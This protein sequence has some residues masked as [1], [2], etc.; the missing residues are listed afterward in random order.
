MA[1]ILAPSDVHGQYSQAD[2]HLEASVGPRER[3]TG[4]GFNEEK[5]LRIFAQVA[6]C[7]RDRHSDEEFWIQL[8][9]EDMGSGRESEVYP[10][11]RMDRVGEE[12]VQLSGGL[13]TLMYNKPR[14]SREERKEHLE[15]ERKLEME[16]GTH[17]T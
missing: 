13:V 7:Q 1:C 14:Y 3:R 10:W 11:E 2:R 17:D 16:R 5:W 9:P 12:V 15:R 4:F 6:I 8:E